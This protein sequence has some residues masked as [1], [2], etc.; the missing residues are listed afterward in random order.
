MKL[1]KVN[2]MQ[3]GTVRLQSQLMVGRDAVDFIL[4]D[5]ILKCWG[6]GNKGIDFYEYYGAYEIVTDI[7]DMAKQPI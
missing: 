5:N 2:E 1:L 6:S 4:K 7:K 3:D